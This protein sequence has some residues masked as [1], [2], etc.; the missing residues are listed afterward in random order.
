MHHQNMCK[1]HYSHQHTEPRTSKITIL[2]YPRMACIPSVNQEVA[3]FVKLSLH[4]VLA[5]S[6]VTDSRGGVVPEIFGYQ[7]SL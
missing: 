4:Y 1:T 6:A 5:T 3:V 2:L 7:Y